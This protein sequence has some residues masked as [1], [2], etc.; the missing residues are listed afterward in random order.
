MGFEA[1]LALQSIHRVV[2]KL[3]H[4]DHGQNPAGAMASPE[5]NLVRSH[6]RLSRLSSVQPSS[7]LSLDAKQVSK[8]R[9]FADNASVLSAAFPAPP[10]RFGLE[11]IDTQ[12]TKP[13]A[14][15]SF[16]DNV[17]VLSEA[18][19]IKPMLSE[20][21]AGDNEAVCDLQQESGPT[22]CQAKA[23]ST[24]KQCK[25]GARHGTILCHV[26]GVALD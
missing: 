26:H 23:K 4:E 21:A 14:K 18:I 17:A 15:R 3:R 1:P 16:V 6:R 25:L 24:G 10:G 19:P 22:R 8:K 9:S 7:I 2:P 11:K 12:P 5:S 20:R 13:T